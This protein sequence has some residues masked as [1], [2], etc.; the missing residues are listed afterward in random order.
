MK[1]EGIYTSLS[2]HPSAF[3]ML[4]SIES[5]LENI[6]ISVRPTSS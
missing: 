4:N 1:G 6:A 3:K 5:S 2:T